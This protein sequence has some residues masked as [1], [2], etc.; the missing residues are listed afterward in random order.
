QGVVF[1]RNIGKN[2]LSWEDLK[3]LSIGIIG[4]IRY[5]DM[6]T[7]GLNRVLA[8]DMRHLFKLLAKNRIDVA[9]AVLEAGKI[10]IHQNY[11]G[12]QIHMIGQPLFEAPL[13]HFVHK[14]NKDLVPK[15][16]A[17]LQKMME[18]GEI[19]SIR[20]NEMKKA[21]SQ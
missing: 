4:G 14:R 7:K 16:E 8:R 12:S 21:L 10:E 5:S 20:E 9:V 6:G 15:L 1:T 2:I 18:N 13:F 17:V 19:A 3:G 11:R